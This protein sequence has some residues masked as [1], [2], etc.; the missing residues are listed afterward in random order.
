MPLP[1][2]PDSP[3]V[4]SPLVTIET[5]LAHHTPTITTPQDH[6]NDTTG[7]RG[8]GGGG[9][10]GEGGDEGIDEDEGIDDWDDCGLEEM[11]QNEEASKLFDSICLEQEIDHQTSWSSRDTHGQWTGGEETT[12]CMI[13][14][15][16]GSMSTGGDDQYTGK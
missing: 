4:L 16:E 13:M 3:I 6:F 5:D 15:N 1:S 2:V 14:D 8:G 9:G 10:G 12:D 7:T 11:L